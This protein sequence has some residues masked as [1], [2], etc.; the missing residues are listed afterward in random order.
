MEDKRISDEDWKKLVEGSFGDKAA[1][2][3]IS[4]DGNLISIEPY[5]LRGIITAIKRLYSE[6]S[7]SRLS[8]DAISQEVFWSVRNAANKADD[9]VDFPT[10]SVEKFCNPGS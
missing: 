2:L 8:C 3:S 6:D 1:I 4:E 9:I 7:F 10:V 5:V